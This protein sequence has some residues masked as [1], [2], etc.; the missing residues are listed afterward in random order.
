M[1]CGWFGRALR[2]PP[3]GGLP[4]VALPRS[5]KFG[6]FASNQLRWSIKPY[7]TIHQTPHKAGFGVWWVWLGSN[8]RPLRCQRSAHT[9][10]L[11]TRFIFWCLSYYLIL[12]L[13][14][15]TF[16]HTNLI[17]LKKNSYTK[18]FIDVKIIYLLFEL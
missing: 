17:N 7:Q 16:L 12:F 13:L 2:T 18:I 3:P 14:A 5:Y 9:T 10:E 6:A 4:S 11:H 8:Q 15:R 1:L